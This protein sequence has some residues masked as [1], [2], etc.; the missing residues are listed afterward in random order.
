M[1]KV[2]F[3]RKLRELGYTD[4]YINK[5]LELRRRD[6]DQGIKRRYEDYLP[7]ARKE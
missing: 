4:C 1:T 6:Q 2:Q 7:V 5:I 3:I